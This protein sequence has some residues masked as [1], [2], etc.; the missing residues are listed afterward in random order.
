MAKVSTPPG[1]PS[2]P[3]ASKSQSAPSSTLLYAT[4]FFVQITFVVWMFV[5][6]YAMSHVNLPPMVFAAY[7]EVVASLSLMA[8]VWCS[9]DPSQYKALIRDVRSHTKSFLVLGFLMFANVA[10]Y[11]TGLSMV[12][13]FNA[14]VLQPTQPIFASFLAWMVRS[15]DMTPA[16]ALSVAMA[17]S[18]AALTVWLSSRSGAGVSGAHRFL[19]EAGDDAEGTE[20]QPDGGDFGDIGNPTLGNGLLLIQC[21]CG[22]AMWVV[23]KRVLAQVRSPV[24]VTAVSYTIAS[25]FT[26]VVTLA[27]QGVRNPLL[28]VTA[29]VAWASILYAAL[30]ATVFTYYAMAWANKW[31]NPSTVTLSSSLQPLM[32]ALI[33]A[34]SGGPMLS[35]SQ[36]LSCVLIVAGLGVKV[37]DQERMA[38]AGVGSVEATLELAAK[39]A[40]PLLP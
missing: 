30:L 25:V 7:R 32:T 6:K 39:E 38:R 36:A 16:K 33:T 21:V 17:T 9:T 18:G 29:P 13:P 35:A 10:G 12:S 19:L 28:V 24:V 14:A 34:L 26:V 20:N 31:A 4:L 1:S 3:L 11:I 15:E 23:Q 40:K 5:A 37:Y 2:R 22:G 27:Q 8:M